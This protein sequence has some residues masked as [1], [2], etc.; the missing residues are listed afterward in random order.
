MS[1]LKYWKQS[2]L[3]PSDQITHAEMRAQFQGAVMLT[4][5]ELSSLKYLPST[6]WISSKQN[7]LER[8]ITSTHTNKCQPPSA[9]WATG[10]VSCIS[11]STT[12]VW[13]KTW[14]RRSFL[15]RAA[16][17][18]LLSGRSRAW[19]RRS[20]EATRKRAA[21]CCA[22]PSTAIKDMAVSKTSCSTSSTSEAV[23]F[24]VARPSRTDSQ[25]QE[26]SWRSQC[27]TTNF[28]HSF[29]WINHH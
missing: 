8:N 20:L 26:N 17:E 7:G 14:C 29:S 24:G 5:F 12:A 25:S 16:V 19:R 1:I 21:N 4:C 22:Q 2:L 11:A 13:W 23:L 6:S 27:G 18:T 9:A 28:N 15:R 10:P 3:M